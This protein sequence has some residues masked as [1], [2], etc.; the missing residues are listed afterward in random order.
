M[1]DTC[2][3]LTLVLC[4]LYVLR[5]GL[6]FLKAGHVAED[7]VEVSPPTF[8][9]HHLSLCGAGD[10]AQGFL[11]ARKAVFLLRHISGPIYNFFKQWE[12]KLF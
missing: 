3:F 10:R 5:Q 1:K 4:L 9:V 7:D 8:S 11:H 2:S 6:K 12:K